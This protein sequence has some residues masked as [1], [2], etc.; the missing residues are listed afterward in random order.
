MEAGSRSC[1]RESGRRAPQ[2][3]S[4]THANILFHRAAAGKI[5]HQLLKRWG[6]GM[7]RDEVRSIAD[8]A[9]CEAAK[10]FEPGRGASFVT[11]LY[12]YIRGF[13]IRE[14]TSRSKGEFL[15]KEEETERVSLSVFQEGAPDFSMHVCRQALEH[16]PDEEVYVRQIREACNQALQILTEVEREIVLRVHVLDFKV[17]AVARQLGYSRGHVSELRRRAF[18]KLQHELEP[19]RRAA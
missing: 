16:L 2:R 12:F 10:G 4:E 7:E 18:T 1:G 17:A 5:A 13:L 3:V 9:L 19:F 15:L 11:Y 6:A 8:L 14:L